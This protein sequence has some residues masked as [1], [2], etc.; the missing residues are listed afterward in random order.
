MIVFNPILAILYFI[1]LGIDIAM[2]FLVVRLIMNHHSV[3]WLAGLDRV[4]NA[5]V[6]GMASLVARCWNSK[7]Q[8][9]LSANGCVIVDLVALTLIKLILS[10]IVQLC[11]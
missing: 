8:K 10:G 3:Q 7:S 6:D 11:L 2:F 4:G 1:N 5:L 9:P